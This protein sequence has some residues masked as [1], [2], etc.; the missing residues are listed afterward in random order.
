MSQGITVLE[1]KDAGGRKE[2]PVSE[3]GVQGQVVQKVVQGVVQK[4][5]QGVVQGLVQE[6]VQGEL[7]LEQVEERV[8]TFLAS[9]VLQE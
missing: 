2:L 5:V 1:K 4:V 3:S 9:E 7:E 8:I 6:V